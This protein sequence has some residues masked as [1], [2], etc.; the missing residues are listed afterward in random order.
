MKR[1]FANRLSRNLTVI[2]CALLLAGGSSNVHA[3]NPFRIKAGETMQTFVLIFHQGSPAPTAEERQRTSGNVIAWAEELNAEGHKL[4]PRILGPESVTR[5]EL[6]HQSLAREELPITA[7]LF[8]EAR[9]LGEVT[10]I[11][12]SHPALRNR[13]LVEVRPWNPPVRPVVNGPK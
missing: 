5:G 7:L 8:L 12:E 11:A 4:D 3:Q 13:I 10:R 6:G 9:D 1:W 2:V